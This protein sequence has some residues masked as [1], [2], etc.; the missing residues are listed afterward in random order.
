MSR[1]WLC[2]SGFTSP[3]CPAYILWGAFGSARCHRSLNWYHC[4]QLPMRPEMQT[5]P[6]AQAKA[7]GWFQYQSL[8]LNS[9][10]LQI[11]PCFCASKHDHNIGQT[12]CLRKCAGYI[13]SPHSQ[14]YLSDTSYLWYLSSYNPILDM[15]SLLSR[16]AMNDCSLWCRKMGAAVLHYLWP[17]G[18][19]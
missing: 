2:T 1:Q 16:V 12:K 13:T 5:L 18:F 11:Y 19:D 8:T 7:S 14:D 17:S 9:Q 10:E 6:Q 3:L 15:L 4:A